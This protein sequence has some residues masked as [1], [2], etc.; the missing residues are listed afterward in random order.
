M[1]KVLFK[2]PDECWTLHA[3]NCHSFSYVAE[4][5]EHSDSDYEP[6]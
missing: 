1:E 5:E 2:F 3:L 6:K 4:R